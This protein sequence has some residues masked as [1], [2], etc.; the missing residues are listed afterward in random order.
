MVDRAVEEMGGAGLEGLQ[1][2]FAF[3]VN[4]NDDNGDFNAVR[5]RAE[6]ADELRAVHNRHLEV[7]D[8]QVRRIMLEPGQRF[9]GGAEAAHAHARFNGGGAPRANLAVSHPVAAYYNR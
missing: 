2:E 8:D 1:P 9:Y 3:L 7:G 6:P 4:G 5:L